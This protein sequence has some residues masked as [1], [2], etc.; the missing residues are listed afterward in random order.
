MAARREPEFFSGPEQLCA[1]L[2]LLCGHADWEPP[3]RL[4]AWS[5]GCAT[6]E[7]AYTLAILL[8]SA[9]P[10]VEIEVVGTDVDAEALGR[11]KEALYSGR[12][13][14]NSRLFPQGAWFVPAG[15]AWRVVD[16]I[17]EKVRFVEHEL[18]SS[19]CPDPARGLADFDLV[20]CRNVL[21][22]LSPAHVPL[23][24]RNIAASCN[25]WS[26][27]ALDDDAASQALCVPGYAS[28]GQALLLRGPTPP[29]PRAPRR[30]P[31][32]PK[33]SM[34]HLSKGA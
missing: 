19:S 22:Y 18:V 33:P 20:V 10:E 16:P 34:A 9:F 4:R 1:L 12:T 21:S 15:E 27:V 11:A 32:R 14:R 24:L 28:A 8:T 7:E 13:L 26:L 23:A 17:R 25:P 3:G 5:A 31:P 2:D 6:G 29:A 30:I